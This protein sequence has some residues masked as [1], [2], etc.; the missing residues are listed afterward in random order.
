MENTQQSGF[1]IDLGDHCSKTAYAWSKKTFKNR[2]KKAGMPCAHLDGAFSN[3]LD[4]HGTNIGISSDGIGTK[5]ELAERT[6]IY[7]TLGYDLMAMVVDDLVA[8]GFEP[9]NI[10]NI[11]DVDY[12]DA[13]IIDDLMRGLHN[14]AD[15]ASVAIS[16]G[17]IAEL[18]KRICGYGPRMHF[19]WCATAI[20]ILHETLEQPIDGSNVQ[21]G[22]MIIAL[23]SRGFRSNGFSLLR[24]IMTEQFGEEWHTAK[25]DET[26]TWGEALLTPA[27]LFAPVICN[28]LDA[29]FFLK[30]I[31]HIT[32]GG[33]EGNLKRVLKIH[34]TGALLDNLF[35]PLEV[36]QKIIKLG[37]IPPKTAYKYWN[38]GNGM[39]VVVG[40]TDADPMLQKIESIAYNAKIVGKITAKQ[41]IQIQ[42]S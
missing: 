36:M 33:I 12:L 13:D 14:A 37:D 32:G 15:E 6:G 24:T 25:Y 3:M 41:G 39:L 42:H 11:L 16:G 40:R 20:G 5:I 29:G 8:G 30:G 34:Q 19:N 27:R 1:D 28:L 21:V 23:Q 17:E 26:T 31:V 18:G 2:E 10:S 35:A 7:H 22:D 38:M 4:F 9:T